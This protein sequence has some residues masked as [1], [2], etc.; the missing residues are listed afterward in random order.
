MRSPVEDDETRTPEQPVR[1]QNRAAAT[2]G[3]E[4]IISPVSL[5]RLEP[6]KSEPINGIL[7]QSVRFEEPIILTNQKN[8]PKNL[9]N[10]II[11]PVEKVTGHPTWQVNSN[12]TTL[13]AQYGSD[14]MEWLPSMY[15][16]LC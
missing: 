14:K 5:P 8:E 7:K 12:L 3:Q 15:K 16:D 6:R 1:L 10:S 4:T 11:K 13:Q 9:E 2:V